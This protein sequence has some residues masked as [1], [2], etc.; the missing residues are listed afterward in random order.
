L[1]V[2]TEKLSFDVFADDNASRVFQKI[3]RSSDNLG[4]TFKRVSRGMLAVGRVAAVGLAAGVGVGVVALG[5]FV[6]EARESER[7]GKLTEAIIKSTGGA[8]KVS[9]LDVAKLSTALSV[10]T[11]IDDELIQTGSNLLLTF[12]NVRDEVGKGNKVFSDATAAALDLSAAGFGSVESASKM[13]GKALN[14]PIAGITALSRAGVTFTAGQKD[15]I[16]AMVEAGDLLGA[17]KLIMKEVESQV[18]GAAAAT[19]TG[20]DKLRVTVGNLA[21]KVGTALLP[22]IDRAST[23]LAEKLPG[24][25]DVVT[26]KLQALGEF[27]RDE[28]VPKIQ[29]FVKWIRDDLTPALQRFGDDVI[30]PAVS[31]LGSLRDAIKTV[32]DSF[33]SGKTKPKD[34]GTSITDMLGLIGPLIGSQLKVAAA[35]VAVLTF[36]FEASTFAVR[37]FARLASTAIVNF[38]DVFLDMVAGTA[39]AMARLADALG[40]DSLAGKLRGAADKIDVFKATVRGKLQELEGVAY[41]ASDSLGGAIGEGMAAGIAGSSGMAVEQARQTVN[42]V[43]AIMRATAGAN[44]PAK[45]T[46]DLGHDILA[47][48]ALGMKEGTELALAGAADLIEK[49]KGKLSEL[50]GEAKGIRSGARD[51]VRGMFD[52]GGIGATTTSTDAE[53]NEVSTTASPVA[54]FADFAAKSQAFAGAVSQGV[55]NGLDPRIVA[56]AVGTGNLAVVQSLAALDP[57]AAG[58]INRDFALAQKMAAQVGA[59]VLSTTSIPADIARVQGTLDTLKEI[60]DDL[61]NNPREIRFVINDATDPDKVVAAIRRYIKK[62]GKLRDVAAN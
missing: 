50:R 20:M 21:E 51:A 36:A 14:D 37:T 6:G 4:S 7:V 10:K 48:L 32:S 3:G 38:S 15:Q 23:W 40:M 49:V 34:F 16:K 53:G 52:W 29:S 35:N 30:P 60:R 9:A 41:K 42:K 1:A 57:G 2:A 33:D 44:S 26:P 39:R 27:I 12:K 62:N 25:I 43:N 18:G 22:H 45:M 46:I 5:K 8:A 28:V 55:A 17:Q 54:Q 11:G 58:S 59:T 31:A 19:A 47:G 61:R 13:L 24:A 56:Q